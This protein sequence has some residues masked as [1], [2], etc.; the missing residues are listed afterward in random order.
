MKKI[1]VLSDIHG[2]ISCAASALRSH[3]E[4]DTVFF[5][6]DGISKIALLQKEYPRLWHLVRGNCDLSSDG[7]FPEETLIELEEHRIFL[8][9]G[10]R[11]FVKHD[12][13]RLLSAA[14]ARGADIVLYGHTHLPAARYDRARAIHLFNPG[15]IGAPYD[16]KFTYGLLTLSRTDVLFS[17]GEQSFWHK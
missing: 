8:T 16:G 4:Y 7:A 17:I 15:S 13:E 3:P 12:E 2:T 5:L 10:H 9:H 14:A 1:L 11:Y 6:G